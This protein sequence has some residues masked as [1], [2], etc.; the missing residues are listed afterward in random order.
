[1]AGSWGPTTNLGTDRLITGY[2]KTFTADAA[3]GSIPAWNA[4]S[5]PLIMTAFT[6]TITDVRVLFGSP[7]P[8]ALTVT[9]VDA[10]GVTLGSIALTAS[11]VLAPDAPIQVS[12]GLSIALT[13]NST[14]SATGTV[15][16]LF[17]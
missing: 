4:T 16:I 15:E 10:L 8:N 13:G 17:L 5:D 3:D 1:M 12:G 9:L 11:G 2:K 14:N 6:G 7:A